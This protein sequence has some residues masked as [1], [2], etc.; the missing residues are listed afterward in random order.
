MAK[1]KFKQNENN[2]AVTYSRFSSHGQDEFSI[3]RQQK[4]N[5]EYAEKH[6]YTVV[7]EYADYAMSGAN[8]NRPD[9]RLMLRELKKIK[10][11]V[12]I[13]WKGNRL[14]RNLANAV[15]AKQK[16]RDAGCKLEYVAEKSPD[17]ET[18]QGK[19][20]ANI[21]D[22]LSQY[23]SD[24]T[25]ENTISG[26]IEKAKQCRYLGHKILGYRRSPESKYEI[27]PKTAPIVVRIF[28]DYINGKGTQQIA[29]ELNSQGLR[30]VRGGKF[31]V[32]GLNKTL[33]QDKYTGIYRYGDIE[34]EGGMPVIIDKDTFDKA[35]KMLRLNKRIKRKDQL[36]NRHRYWLSGKLYCGHCGEA[37]HGVSGT[38][39]TQKIHYYYA[40]GN[41]RKHKCD[42]K[43]VKAEAIERIVIDIL[44]DLLHDDENLVS[45]AVDAHTF[46]KKQH[47]EALYLKSLQAKLKDTET[48]LKNHIK[49]IEKGVFNE[50]TQQAMLEREEEKKALLEAIEVEEMKQRMTQT[51]YSIKEYIKKFKKSDLENAEIRDSIL[52]YFI[53]K[54]YLYDDKIVLTGNYTDDKDIEVTFEEWQEVMETGGRGFD[55]FAPCSTKH[56]KF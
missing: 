3:E 20:A 18:A 48:A 12:V 47:G 1:R 51:E 28:N 56:L 13:V 29:D 2:L 9:Y 40:C 19:L 53:D 43:Y 14:S 30:T 37:M 41:M 16:I 23:F 50:T 4:L 7:K 8:D 36:E 55:L 46:Y 31:N 10:P 15:I 21:A 27:D 34:I 42:K 11:A 32:N 6:G 49:A 5:R 44:N 38:S 54:I 17:L 22:V 26:Q 35:Q 39:K 33:K 24:E 52:D 45:L 25:R